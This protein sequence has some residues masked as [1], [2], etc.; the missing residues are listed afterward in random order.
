MSLLNKIHTMKL[1][2]GPFD[3]MKSGKKTIEVRC[4]DEKRRSVKVGDTIIFSRYNNPNDTFKVKVIALQSFDTF[5]ELYASFPLE[6]FGV[7]D[8]TIDSMVETVDEIYTDEDQLKYGALAITVE[9]QQNTKT[10]QIS[11]LKG[12]DRVRKRPSVVYGSADIEGAKQAV[13]DL[14]NIFATE[15]QLG[16]CKHL[17]VVHNKENMV[18]YGDDRGIYLGQD[19]GDDTVWKNLFSSFYCPPTNAPSEDGYSFVLCDTSHH[20]LYGDPIEPCATFFPEDAGYFELYCSQCVSKV[21]DVVSVRN[22]KKAALHFENGY[23]DGGMRTEQT[24]DSDGTYFRFVLDPEVFTETIIPNEFFLETLHRFAMLSPGLTCSYINDRDGAR[25]EFSYPHGVSDY[26]KGC[27]ESET[28]SVYYKKIQGKAKER[29]NS[30]EYEACLEVAISPALNHGSTLCFHN[31]RELTYGGTHYRQMQK[32][33]CEV[34]N[35]YFLSY[36][37]ENEPKDASRRFKL[38]EKKAIRFDE[39]SKHLTIVLA[40]W[41]TPWCSRWENGS[42]LSIAN[43]TIEDM[44]YDAISVEFRNYVYTNKETLCS[45]VDAIIQERKFSWKKLILQ[46]KTSFC[47][48]L[49]NRANSR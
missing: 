32:R 1:Y 14:L 8:Q 25:T 33:V 44:T 5:K 16:H 10:N 19:S 40:S 39:L 47:S 24:E 41:C 31:F 29:Y 34:F 6:K 45:I 17:T 26:V 43:K 4:N 15:A 49:L 18:I 12:P 23:N 27:A 7:T 46:I 3:L 30:A 36:I 42:R 9:V 28:T 38:R 20:I 2:D 37:V 48:L 11:R 13:R 22:G 35:D 21:M